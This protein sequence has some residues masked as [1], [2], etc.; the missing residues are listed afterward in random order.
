MSP[1]GLRRNG[2]R[3]EIYALFAKL[4]DCSITPPARKRSSPCYF[5]A[6]VSHGL[7]AGS[8]WVCTR[9][10]PMYS[11]QAGKLMFS[12]CRVLPTIIIRNSQLRA[13]CLALTG[14]AARGRDLRLNFRKALPCCYFGG[15]VFLMALRGRQFWTVRCGE[16]RRAF[17]RRSA[18]ALESLA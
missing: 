14:S 18:F 3:Y 7:S 15:G 1:E 2:T 9:G 11:P 16:R 6:L 12:N 17:F 8:D 10:Y 13:A 5:A 4:Q